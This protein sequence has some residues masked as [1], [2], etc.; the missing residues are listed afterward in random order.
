VVPPPTYLAGLLVVA[1][2]VG[3]ALYARRPPITR[4]LVI[5][6]TPW[7]VTGAAG[8]ARFQLGGTSPQVAPLLSAPTV[9]VSTF[10]VAATVWAAATTWRDDQGPG[11]VGAAGVVTAL[12]ASGVVLGTGLARGTL[13]PVIPVVG[14]AASVALTAGVYVGLDTVR[15]AVTGATGRLGVLVLFGHVLDGVSTTIGI[16]LL[17]AGEQSPLPRTIMDVAGSLPTA[18]LIGTGWLFVLVKLG[19]AVGILLLF[20]DLVEE[21]PVFGNVALGIVT[22]VGLGPGAH[23][24]LLF[25]TAA[26]A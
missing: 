12:A 26:P 21:D 9:Y 7:M 4:E 3:A 10:A 5:A 2:V 23:N 17:G 11:V 19:V 16:D 15:P 24:L 13:S 25:A 6:F 14:L 20:A 18:D 22:A 1:A 8:Y